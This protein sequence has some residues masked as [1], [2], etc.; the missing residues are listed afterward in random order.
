MQHKNN[1]VDVGL[2]CTSPPGR[3]L[4]W[5]SEKPCGLEAV[6]HWQVLHRVLD[7]VTAYS[8]RHCRSDRHTTPWGNTTV[9]KLAFLQSLSLCCRSLTKAPTTLQSA[10]ACITMRMCVA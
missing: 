4:N 9:S 6:S 10:T 7:S 8:C 1:S 5:K 3:Q 2:A